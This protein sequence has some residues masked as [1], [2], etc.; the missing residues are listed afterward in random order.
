M[1]ANN[2]NNNYSVTDQQ[3]SEKTSMCVAKSHSE[4]LLFGRA[5]AL[6][7]TLAKLT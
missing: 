1:A 4:E 5:A 7:A 2:I 3:G 6:A